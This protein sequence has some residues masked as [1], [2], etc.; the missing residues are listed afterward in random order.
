MDENTLTAQLQQGYDLLTEI[1]RRPPECFAA[2]AWQVTPEALLALDRF[3]FRYESSCRG[4]SVFRPVEAGKPLSHVQVPTTLPTYDELIGRQCTPQTYNDHLLALI[5]PDRLNVL[6]IH[7]EVEGICC[8][9]LFEEF[10][11]K[12]TQRQ[13]AFRPLGSMVPALETIS[14]GVIRKGE[15]AGRE[16]WLASQA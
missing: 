6:T 9:E 3:D 15:I 10:L 11:D 1:L 12:A 14:E 4:H 8:H 2:P 5:R 16:G 7:A 13:I